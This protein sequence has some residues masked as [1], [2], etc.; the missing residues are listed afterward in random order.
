[1]FDLTTAFTSY[2]ALIPI[3]VGLVQVC[4]VSGLPSRW[5]PLCSL[6]FGVGL[7][8]LVQA[9]V[10]PVTLGMTILAG[11]IVGLSASGLYSQAKATFMPPPESTDTVTV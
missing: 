7:A 8:F 3:V 10:V 11:L 9:M 6:V 4:K 2:L 1:M 5:A